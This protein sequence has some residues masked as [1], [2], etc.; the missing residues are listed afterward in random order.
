[1]KLIETILFDKEYVNLTYHIKRVKR[2]YLHFKWK[3][4]KKEWENLPLLPYKNTPLRVRITYNQKGINNIELFKI[5]KREFK[6]LKIVNIDFDYTFKYKNRK[7]FE[8]L[9]NKYN[10]DEFILVKNSLITDTT[11]SNLAFFTGKE[12]ITPKAPLLKG[13][14]R[15]ELLDKK[16]LFEAHIK[17]SDIKHF[18]KI[19][20]IN[21]ILGFKEIALK[22]VKIC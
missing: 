21:A 14:K 15:A 9:H 2:T 8:K 11:I 22:D 16:K 19:A 20:L 4:N 7:N 17:P 1:M 10:A 12:W 6:T 13:T 18:K 5:K 3:F